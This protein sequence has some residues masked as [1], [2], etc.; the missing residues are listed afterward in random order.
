LAALSIHAKRQ[1]TLILPATVY[2]AGDSIQLNNIHDQP[3]PT[4]VLKVFVGH[5]TGDIVVKKF[6]FAEN[7]VDTLLE[8]IETEGLRIIST[9]SNETLLD[10]ADIPFL[11]AVVSGR[12]D[13]LVT[14]NKR[15]FKVKSVKGLKILNPDGLLK[16]W[17]KV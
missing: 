10:K 4:E 9:V 12:A 7:E 11:K 1:E 13:A 5:K 3:L 2:P 17:K 6:G 15:H 14:G 8:Y 16:L